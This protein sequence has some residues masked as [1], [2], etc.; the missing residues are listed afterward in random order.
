MLVIN[1][2]FHGVLQQCEDSQS[3]FIHQHYA[4][5]PPQYFCVFIEVQLQ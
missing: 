4:R 1:S 3:P 2:S 5:V